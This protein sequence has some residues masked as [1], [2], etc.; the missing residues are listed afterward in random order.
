[1]MGGDG[2]CPAGCDSGNDADCPATTSTTTTTLPPLCAPA[3]A[4][5]CR[6]AQS[7]AS[8]VQ[9]KDNGDNTKDQ[10]KWKWAK[11]AA[12]D[13]TNFKDPV[14]G[15]ATYRLCVYD[16]SGHSQPLMQMDVPPGGMCG[17]KA[18]W[19]ARGTT[20]FGYKN[21]AGTPNGLTGMKLKAGATGEAQVQAKGKGA[22]LPTPTLGLTLPV[23][24]QFVAED[25]AG[26]EC[27]QTSYSSFTAN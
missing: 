3:P 4:T 8:S 18:G 13:V 11:G 16:A 15:S 24:V 17:T 19:K 23:T 2:C 25:G 27:W 9:I 7:G 1:C 21:K 5:G 6:L 26:T 20:G 14:S 10:F 12:T 22:N